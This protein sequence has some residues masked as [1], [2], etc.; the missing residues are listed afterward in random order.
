MTG[1]AA[2]G[3]RESPRPVRN[4]DRVADEYDASRGGLERGRRAAADLAPH[5]VP[6]VATEGTAQDRTTQ[7]RT[8]PSRVLEI[9]VGT[10]IVAEALLDLAG[11]EIGTLVGV[12]IS[13][14][15][16]ARATGRLPGRLVRAS[17]LA[18]PFPDESFDDVVGVHILHLVTDLRTTLSEAARVLRPGG[19]V[20]AVHGD[21]QHPPG[22]ELFEVT[23]PMREL[24]GPSVDSAEQVVSAATA[25]GLRCLDQ[26]PSSPQRAQ[27]TPAELADLVEGRSWSS[28]WDLD[29]ALWQERIAPMIA[30]I[31]ALPD[32]H[33]PR[34]QEARTTVTVLERP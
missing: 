26:H 29:D 1:A 16:L 21:P 17:A 10:G 33:R 12:D 28:L 24:R 18:L 19:R 9:G 8:A 32:Q 27:H 23:L 15:M 2:G 5:L 13:R 6:A 25:A 22:D 7:E 34:P 3:A 31:R 4:F 11:A 30:R 14:D 20:V